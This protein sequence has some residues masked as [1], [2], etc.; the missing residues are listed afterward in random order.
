MK[1]VLIIDDDMDMREVMK[2]VLGKKYEIKEAGSKKD[3][4]KA[5]TAYIPDLII[6]D[7]MMESIKAGFEM[8]REVKQDEKLK[9]VKILM[10]TN[11]DNEFKINYQAEAGD[12]DWLPVDDY[13]VKPVEPK[14][15]LNKV[16]KLLK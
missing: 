10:L 12:A 14:T 13:M 2:V 7:V 8:A 16:D 5:L 3:G 11:I 9:D 6:L 4:L 15:L 1:K